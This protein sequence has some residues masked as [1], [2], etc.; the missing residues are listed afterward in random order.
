MRSVGEAPTWFT[1]RTMVSRLVPG[2]NLN[3]W[4]P[5]SLT[6]TLLLGTTTVW[7]LLK[8]AGWLTCGCSLMVTWIEPCATAAGVTRTSEPITTVPVREFTTTRAG[9]SP[10]FTSSAWIAPSHATRWLASTG[11]R[12]LAASH[13]P[14]VPMIRHTKLVLAVL[15]CIVYLAFGGASKARGAPPASVVSTTF[16][17]TDADIPNPDRGFYG[18]AGTDFVSGF[19]AAGARAAFAA[20]QRLVLAPVSLARFREAAGDFVT[21]PPAPEPL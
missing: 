18:W 11:P 12:T 5:S 15:A 13:F 14:A 4:P 10:G 19:D 17:P 7:P 21:P 8:G 6:C 20:G 16:Q 2:P 9:A 3:M 1:A